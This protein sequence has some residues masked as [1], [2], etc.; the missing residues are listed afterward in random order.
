MC[1]LLVL[2]QSTVIVI[3]PEY[4][5]RGGRSDARTAMGASL[6]ALGVFPT[7]QAQSKRLSAFQKARVLQ[8]AV[9]GG[10][11]GKWALALGDYI[12]DRLCTEVWV[13]PPNPL[14]P[15]GESDEKRVVLHTPTVP[16]ALHFIGQHSSLLA[17]M[18]EDPTDSDAAVIRL[19]DVGDWSELRMMHS[20]RFPSHSRKCEMVSSSSW[21]F[22]AFRGCHCHGQRAIAC[23]GEI[24]GTPLCFGTVMHHPT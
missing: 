19:W 23:D 2:V 24:D 9:A 1:D 22:S 5:S 17:I 6:K 21:L 15:F 13:I 8:M 4:L 18:C 16:H 11:D 10:P 20:G 3:A 7:R 12:S 14:G